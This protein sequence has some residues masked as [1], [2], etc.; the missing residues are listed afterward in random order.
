MSLKVASVFTGIGSFEH[1]LKKNNIPHEILF[2]CDI[3]KFC[4]KNYLANYNCN[5]WYDGID[6]IEKLKYKNKIDLIVGG[7]PCQSF[8]IAGLRKGLEDDRGDLLIKYIKLIKYLKPKMFILENVKGLLNHNGG[9]TFEVILDKFRETGYN[10]EYSII[11]SKKINFPQSRERI[12][13]IGYKKNPIKNVFPL[14]EEELTSNMESYLDK[15]V[16]SKYNII[17]E[18]WQ[19]LIFTKQKLDKQHININGKYIICQT[20]R[21]YASWAGNFIIEEKKGANFPYIEKAKEIIKDYNIIPIGY[22]KKKINVNYILKNSILRR[23]TPNECLKLMGFDIIKFKNVCSD[24][25]CYK[26]CGNSIIVNMFDKIFEKMLVKYI[27]K[28][29]NEIVL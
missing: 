13:V 16:D 12:F 8:S 3:D 2:A 28:T 18:K 7:S 22:S 17:N 19:N 29:T 1:S 5:Q 11:S 21:Q 26:Q 10:L 9:E 23:L 27:K 20:A 24:N 4:K 6:N 15:N 14:K 25:Q